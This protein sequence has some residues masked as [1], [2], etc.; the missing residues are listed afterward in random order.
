MATHTVDPRSPTA[1]MCGIPFLGKNLDV[2]AIINDEDISPTC[3]KCLNNAASIVGRLDKAL[4]D[5][6]A[7]NGVSK[8]NLEQCVEECFTQIDEKVL[9]DFAQRED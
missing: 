2:V 9:D 1:T 5:Y 4:E 7:I 8:E 3:I 6:A